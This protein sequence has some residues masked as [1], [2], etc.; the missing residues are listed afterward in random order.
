VNELQEGSSPVIIDY[1]R[2][3]MIANQRYFGAHHIKWESDSYR[4][5]Q[6][7]A[8]FAGRLCYLSFGTESGVTGGHHTVVGRKTN[9]EYLEHLIE[10]GHESVLEHAVYSFL[11]EGVSRSLTHELVR[12]RI[13]MSYS[14]L[15]QRYVDESNVA[16]VRPPGIRPG[17]TADKCWIMA[18]VTALE[19]YGNLLNHL[20]G[21]LF[22]SVKQRREIARAVLPN[23]VET[24]IVVTGNARAW[25][26]FLKLRRA[27]GADAEMQRLAD[28]LAVCLHEEAPAIF[29]LRGGHP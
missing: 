1:P 10:E 3:T 13:G 19:S 16:F 29:P 17:T 15:S 2:I 28:E 14:Q 4:G 12:H 5:G 23:C 9:A 26:H 25:R 8:E 20:S 27:K 21:S 7:L 18:C 11:L 6:A 22:A 24:K